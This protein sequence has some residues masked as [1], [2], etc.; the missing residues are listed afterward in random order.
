MPLDD[1]D[2]WLLLSFGGPEQ[3]D[4]VM[5]F[6]ENV[7]RGRD[8]PVERLLA[9]AEQYQLFGGRSP[10]NDH[11]RALREAVCEELDRRGHSLLSGWG[12]RNWAPF[13]DDAL[14]ELAAEGARKTL[15]LVTSAFSSF[16]GCRQYHDDLAGAISR[17]PDAPLVRRTRVFWNHPDYLGTVAD[18][19]TASRAEAGWGPAVTTVFTAHS[20]PMAQAAT[21]DYEGQLTEAVSLVAD[22]AGLTGEVELAY[23][24]RSG[25]PQVPW[26]EPDVG[27]TLRSLAAADVDRV[28]VVPL[29]FVSDHMEVVY[30]LDT[31]AAATADEV[32]ITM[33]RVPTPG[34]HP[35]F[36]AMLVDLLEEAAGV[37]DDR[38]ALGT[39]GPRPDDCDP[40]CCPAPQRGQPAARS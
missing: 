13:L 26:L 1:Y 6:L 16:S 10:I 15:C 38:P 17:V 20:I 36:V 40:G 21:S 34:T 11:C 18:R 7:T 39:A 19:I 9:V 31:L 27:D 37:R 3:P 24:S 23:Q 29:G 33:E 5:P 14:R 4:H 2:S 28:L 8:V 35:R 12:N 30:D 25:P 22:L 32:G